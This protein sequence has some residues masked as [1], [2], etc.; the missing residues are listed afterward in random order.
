MSKFTD[1]LDSVGQSSVLPMGFS[2]NARKEEVIQLACVGLVR[3]AGTLT[4]GLAELKGLRAVVLAGECIDGDVT[5]ALGNSLWGV[6]SEGLSVERLAQL[7]ERGCDFLVGQAEHL[8][9]ETDEDGM[10]RLLAVSADM[11][12]RLLRTIEDL[13]VDGVVLMDIPLESPLTV[14]H[15]MQLGSIRTMFEKHLLVEAPVSL[16]CSDL[17]ALRDAG[18]SGIVVTLDGVPRHA[19][20]ELLNRIEGIPERKAPKKPRGGS[21]AYLPSPRPGGMMDGDEEVEGDDDY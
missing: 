3:T 6:W 7:K 14:H 13:P 1:V 10:G 2:T 20:E 15:L 4:D 19:L 18:V 17:K 8:P 9:V 5:E 11:D 21:V 12:D 16:G